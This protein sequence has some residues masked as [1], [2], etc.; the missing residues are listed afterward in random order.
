MILFLLTNWKTLVGMFGTA[1]LAYLLHTVD[2][3]RIEA[4]QR[5][6]ITAQQDAD[7]TK[8]DN[9]KK[10]TEGVSHDYQVK[11]SSLSAQ[12]ASIKRLRPAR[13]I[14][15][16]ITSPATGR[17]AAPSGAE[18]PRQDGITSDALYDF[19]NA[20]ERVRLQLVGCQSFVTQTQ[21]ENQ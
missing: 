1:A 16:P 18:L 14:A 15:V 13:C 20:A 3:D 19:A 5:A 7:K 11:L 9:A 12:L 8:C 17:D 6:A 21:Q 10:I 4:Q 2:V